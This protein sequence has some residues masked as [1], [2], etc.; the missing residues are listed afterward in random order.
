MPLMA[1]DSGGS[2]FIP[3]PQGTHLAICNMVVDLGLQEKTYMG[4][5]KVA[6]QCFIR[7]ELPN[8]RIEYEKDGQRV[9]GPMSIGKTYTLSLGDKANL[10]K[11]LEAWRGR[12]F[13]EQEKAGFDLFVLAGLPCQVTITH[14]DRNGKT[15]ANVVGIAG[16]PK[17]MERPKGAENPVVKYGLDD[18]NAQRVYGDL[19][20]WIREKLEKR[21]TQAEDRYSGGSTA[22]PSD[23]G[24]DLDDDIPF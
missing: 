1:K 2:D 9:N 20:K 16:W 8:E 10:K 21:I 22:D 4:E 17:G 5:T 12:A 7:W 14:A 6:H 13:T 3:V 15:Y 23:Y 24:H 18:P 19:P 11:D